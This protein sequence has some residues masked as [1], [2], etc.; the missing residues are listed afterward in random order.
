MLIRLTN[1]RL[2]FP[3]L[4]EARSFQGEG[5]AAY[6]AAFILEKGYGVFLVDKVAKTKKAITIDEAINLAAVDKWEKKAPVILKDLNSK[7]RTCLHDGDSKGEYEGFPGNKYIS[8][9]STAK[10]TVVDRDTTVLSKDSG[11]PDAGCYV[12]ADLEIWGLDNQFGKRICATLKGVQ[13]VKDGEAFSGSA[14]S[15]PGDF[16]SVEEETDLV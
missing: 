4:Y 14:P 10:V 8:A 16:D 9:R 11:K 6:G 15:S 3:N 1:A 2:A 7:D 12:N 13:Y 5:A